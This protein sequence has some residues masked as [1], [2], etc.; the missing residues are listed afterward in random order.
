MDIN[1]RSIILTFATVLG[2]ATI[3]SFIQVGLFKSPITTSAIV[4]AASVGILLVTYRTGDR[5]I[6]VT[7]TVLGGVGIT[8]AILYSVMQIASGT[9]VLTISLA[10]LTTMFLIVAYIIQSD[11]EIV[12]PSHLK[13]AFGVTVILAIIV[14]GVDVTMATPQVQITHYDSV[15]QTTTGERYH[16]QYVVGEVVIKNDAPLPQEVNRDAV[17]SNRACLTGVEPSAL[18]NDSEEANHLQNEFQEIRLAYST[19][20]E[21]LMSYGS[22]QSHLRFPDHFARLISQSD[23]YELSDITVQTA[24]SCPDSTDDP[25]LTIVEGSSTSRPVAL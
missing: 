23:A 18:T 22:H 19:P 4:L 1:A 9:L 13:I 24:D 25:T 7:G 8:A 5:E 16:S 15:Q 12:Q 21:P 2:V 11:D 14:V 6:E 20:Y 10:F 3:L 17:P